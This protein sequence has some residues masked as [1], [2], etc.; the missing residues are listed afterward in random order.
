MQVGEI[1][2]F[3][4]MLEIISADNNLC[5]E[6]GW[7]WEK[8]GFHDSCK[9]SGPHRGWNQEQMISQYNLRLAVLVLGYIRLLQ[10]LHDPKAWSWMFSYVY[11]HV[12]RCVSVWEREGE[13]TY[14]VEH[15]PLCTFSDPLLVFKVIVNIPVSHNNLISLSSE[16][17]GF[18]FSTGN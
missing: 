10:G 6:E 18:S 12:S 7:P 1:V 15:N 13:S 5:R 8:S 3:E 14:Q 4:R 17:S 16:A 2:P 11:L 9:Y